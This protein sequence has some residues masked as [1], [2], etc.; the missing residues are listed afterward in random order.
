METLGTR[1][2]RA[3][4]SAAEVNLSTQGAYAL[5]GKWSATAAIP[6]GYI[7]TDSAVT[8]YYLNL[9]DGTSGA[10]EPV[11]GTGGVIDDGTARYIYFDD[12]YP[13]TMGTLV[14]VAAQPPDGAL[15]TAYGYGTNPN[16]FFA[17]GGLPV[18][19]GGASPLTGVE[20]YGIG[21]FTP[22]SAGDIRPDYVQRGS[23]WCFMT[24]APKL[25]IDL[26]P[27]V[28][29]GN[30]TARVAI[31]GR[32]VLVA[33][34]NVG[35]FPAGNYYHFDWQGARR[36][37]SYEASC[38]G[39]FYF[40]GITV[41]PGSIV[42]APGHV[43]PINALFIGDDSLT[44]DT[45]YM[46]PADFDVAGIVSKTMGW[47]NWQN[48]WESGASYGAST[49]APGVARF[50]DRPRNYLHFI[51][52]DIVIVWGGMF[53]APGTLRHDVAQF[54]RFLRRE[55]PDAFFIVMGRLPDP[56]GGGNLNPAVLQTSV[57]IANGV[58]DA[59]DGNTSFISVLSAPA[60]S[61]LTGTGN[62]GTPATPGNCS[63]YISD[64][65]TYKLAPTAPRY[66]AGR[67]VSALRHLIAGMP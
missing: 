4:A 52:P 43:N 16:N 66:I 51:N 62:M 19:A 6:A 21:T 31:D 7:F 24:D 53:N 17:R 61:W 54:L 25:Q 56:N 44:P 34:F 26:G 59:A 64:V 58:V 37:R 49:I 45:A 57:D 42:W 23:A 27:L 11:W 1:L 14:T 40:G 60:G 63:V 55:L 28:T 9:Q 22:K 41:D 33:P 65:S 67:M 48:A 8:Q 47:T 3:S 38:N 35:S 13:A 18:L 46:V 32:Q 20:R 2:R 30:D 5:P 12:V 36:P 15:T 10:T 50:M 29:T 39:V